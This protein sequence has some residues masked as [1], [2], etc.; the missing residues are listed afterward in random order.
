MNKTKVDL[1]ENQFK[2]IAAAHKNNTGVRVRLS[3][4]KINGKGKY[5]ILLNKAQKEKLDKCKKQQKGGIL[6]LSNEQIKIGGFLPIFVGIA[7]AIGALT[8][9]GAAIANSVIS[10]KHQKAEEEEILRHN[11]EMKK[12][13]KNTKTGSG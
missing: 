13:A 7:T 8:G 12:I 2:K 5:K 4:E 6:E 1:S 9:G 10:A 11:K 3:H